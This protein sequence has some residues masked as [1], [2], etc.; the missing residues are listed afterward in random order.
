M[1][2]VFLEYYRDYMIDQA[3]IDHFPEMVE[4][5]EEH[6][7]YDDLERWFKDE[8]SWPENVK[9]TTPAKKRMLEAYNDWLEY[10]EHE[11]GGEGQ[12]LIA[13]SRR[14]ESTTGRSQAA[15]LSLGSM[16]STPPLNVSLDYGSSPQSQQSITTPLTDPLVESTQPRSKQQ[17]LQLNSTPRSTDSHR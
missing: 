17:K 1:R 14:Q 16:N 2:S 10:V 13:S 12:A 3:H 11:N 15:S 4:Y 5:F 8:K 9:P 7:D 6:A